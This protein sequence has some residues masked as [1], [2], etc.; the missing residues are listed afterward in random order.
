MDYAET[1]RQPRR[2]AAA[3]AAR[4]ADRRR[5]TRRCRCSGRRRRRCAG[6]HDEPAPGEAVDIEVDEQRDRPRRHP[7]LHLVRDRRHRR[8]AGQRAGSPAPATIRTSTAPIDIRGGAF[9]VPDLGH[10][11][12]RTRHAHR[13]DAG[14]ADDQRVQDPRQPRLPDDRRRHAGVARPRGRRRQHHASQS[15]NFEVIDNEL[16]DLKLEHRPADHRRAAQAAR[17]GLDRRRERH[18]PRRAAARAHRRRRLLDGGRRPSSMAVPRPR[19]SRRRRAPAA[20]RRRRAAPEPSLFDALEMDLGLARSEQP[21]AARQRHP[22]GERADRDR[23]HERHRRRRP[24]DPQGAR[25]R[26]AHRSARST[27]SAAATPSRGAASTSCATAASASPAPRRS[28]RCS[29]SA[30]AAIIS[31]VET[32]VRVQGHDA[33]AGAVVQQQPAARSGGHPLADRL[34]PADQRAR[35]GTAGHRWRSAPARWPAAT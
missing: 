33:R 25:R 12:H 34:Q 9:A 10:Q 14:R 17:R 27:P 16:A 26:G 4:V 5:A 3:D 15:E 23:R 20:P 24:A 11:L 13:P 28:T 19:A 21:G 2:P 31:G 6:A 29:T 8:A 30:R 1:R 35:R 18:H 7:G 22:P 32:F